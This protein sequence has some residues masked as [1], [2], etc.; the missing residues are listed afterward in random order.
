MEGRLPDTCV[1]CVGGGSNAMGLFH[2]FVP[3]PAVKLFG[4]SIA[5]NMFKV[6]VG[7]IGGGSRLRRHE[8]D[9]GD[10]RQ[11]RGGVL[12]ALHDR[13]NVGPALVARLSVVAGR[14]LDPKSSVSS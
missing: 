4:D 1:A 11:R 3:D 8:P 7:E 13:G 5:A 14:V 2:A 10:A 12:Q 6:D 9:V